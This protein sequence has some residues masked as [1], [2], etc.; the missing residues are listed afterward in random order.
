MPSS[1]ESALVP[2]R[3]AARLSA[4]GD[5]NRSIGGHDR[6]VRPEARRFVPVRRRYTVRPIGERFVGFRQLDM[7]VRDRHAAGAGMHEGADDR[8]PVA[9][10]I[11]QET[12]RATHVKHHDERQPEGRDQHPGAAGVHV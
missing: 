11:E 4:S 2:V 10:K 9:P 8:D 3:R 1:S 6:G 5:T 7:I 12:N